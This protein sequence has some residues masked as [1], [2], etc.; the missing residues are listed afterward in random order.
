MIDP[1]PAEDHDET[2][3]ETGVDTELVAPE[4]S[5]DTD[6]NSSAESEGVEPASDNDDSDDTDAPEVDRVTKSADAWRQLWGFGP[7]EEQ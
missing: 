4:E 2:S 3:A 7:K 6:D 5:F 1:E